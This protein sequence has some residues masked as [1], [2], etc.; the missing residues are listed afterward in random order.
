MKN[1]NQPDKVGNWKFDHKTDYSLI[2]RNGNKLAIITEDKISIGI[3]RPAGANIFK[4]E[5]KSIEE[6]LAILKDKQYDNTRS[7]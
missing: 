2:Y 6:G 7:Q 1:F 5:I 4:T 3:A